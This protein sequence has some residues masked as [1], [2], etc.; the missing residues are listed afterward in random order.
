NWS[1][2]GCGKWGSAGTGDGLF[3]TISDVA[4]SEDGLIAVLDADKNDIQLFTDGGNMV[5]Q[6][7]S[8]PLGIAHASG[9]AWGHDGKLY[10]ADT[11]TNRVMRV[12]R[13]GE[14]D[15]TYEGGG[16]EHRS[17]EQP[18]DVAVSR[19]GDIY[20]VDLRGRVVHLTPDG[21]VAG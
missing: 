18:T 2:E 11:A 21:A 17:L 8:G 4:V 16:S 1:G 19:D 10:V 12:Q 7:G 9:I 13:T 3:G 6:L 15:M 5:K 20:A 14:P